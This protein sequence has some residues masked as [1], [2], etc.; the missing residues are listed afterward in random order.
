[1]GIMIALSSVVFAQPLPH[2]NQLA[3]LS[4][5]TAAKGKKAGAK[6]QTYLDQA[7]NQAVGQQKAREKEISL[8]KGLLDTAANLPVTLLQAVEKSTLDVQT[9][10]RIVVLHKDVVLALKGLKNFSRPDWWQAGDAADKEASIAAQKALFGFEDLAAA[11][12]SISDQ[13]TREAIKKDLNHQYYVM[14]YWFSLKEAAG[15]VNGASLTAGRGVATAKLNA[16]A[17]AFYESLK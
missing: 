1:M 5:H 10:K 8:S 2:Y 7:L 11:V 3:E 4:E 16:D 13:T 12:N 9:A 14:G 17:Q 6:Q 15:I